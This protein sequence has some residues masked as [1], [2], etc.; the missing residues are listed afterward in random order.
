MLVYSVIWLSGYCGWSSI[1]TDKEFNMRHKKISTDPTYKIGVAAG[2]LGISVPLLRIYEQEGLILSGRTATGRRMYS[3][4]EIEKVRCIRRM[5]GEHGLN[6]EGIRRLLALV[7]CWRL[8]SCGNHE[9]TTCPAYINSE[10]PC[11]STEEKCS[12]P[13]ESCRDCVVYQLTVDCD[14]IKELIYA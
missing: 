2:K 3:N 12:N 9:K 4:L 10:R 1:Q 8:R 14:T 5:I 7:P 13:L 6:Y 11:W